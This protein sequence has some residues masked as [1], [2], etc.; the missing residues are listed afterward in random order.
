MRRPRLILLLISI[1]LMLCTFWGRSYYLADTCQ[2]SAAIPGRAG[3][4]IEIRASL[5]RVLFAASFAGSDA[6][7]WISWGHSSGL[8]RFAPQ[9]D[10]DG[11]KWYGAGFRRAYVVLPY[12]ALLAGLGVFF[13]W[14]FYRQHRAL[15]L[16]RGR[17]CLV[18][19]Y[20]LRASG[21]RCPE[22]GTSIPV[23][24]TQAASS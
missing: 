9:G 22:C 16:A 7:D 12:W 6:R 20:D 4:G 24:S 8:A 19:G 10:R 3:A 23:S 17:V 5:G 2:L 1:T 18:C 21:E 11:R 13:L 14:R 15:K